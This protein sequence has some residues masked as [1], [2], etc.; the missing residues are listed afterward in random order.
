MQTKYILR[1][2]YT[3]RR[4]VTLKRLIIPYVGTDTEQPELL[5][6]KYNSKTTLEKGLTVS[7][8]TYHT[9]IL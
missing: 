9:P 8:K 7:Y 5:V 4:T 6:G 2:H 3:L 1:Y